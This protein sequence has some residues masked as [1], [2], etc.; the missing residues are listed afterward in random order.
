[1]AKKSAGGASVSAMKK[2]LMKRERAASSLR[3]KRERVAQQ[4]RSIDR[5]LEAMGL[6]PGG[7]VKLGFT[8]AGA[9]RKRPV[10]KGTLVDALRRTLKGRTM[11]VTDLTSAVQRGGYKTTAANFRTI[12]NQTLIRLPRV[13]KKVSRGKYTA[14]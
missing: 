8:K 12:V 4:L 14:A 3:Q 13:F 2:D 6:P 10:N 9:P 1:M 7:S 11:S 5:E